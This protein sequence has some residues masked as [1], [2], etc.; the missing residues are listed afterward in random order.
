MTQ[1]DLA[2][3]L[4]VT[5]LRDHLHL[6]VPTVQVRAASVTGHPKLFV[7][8]TPVPQ[9]NLHIVYGYFPGNKRKRI[10]A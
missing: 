3:A 4:A 9:E 1:A 8:H 2:Q 7:M 10:F 6:Q 5:H